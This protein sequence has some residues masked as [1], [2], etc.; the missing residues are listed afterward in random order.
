MRII[1]TL[2]A[3]FLTLEI[4]RESI[5]L[6][7]IIGCFFY[8]VLLWLWKEKTHEP[9]ESNARVRYDQADKASREQNELINKSK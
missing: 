5:G 7:L 4:A 3:I 1:F 9:D 6:A 8:C 2:L